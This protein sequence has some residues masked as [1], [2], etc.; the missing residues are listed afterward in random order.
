[1]ARH[2]AT[3]ESRKVWHPHPQ[4]DRQPGRL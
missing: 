1:M 2:A 3:S 4:G